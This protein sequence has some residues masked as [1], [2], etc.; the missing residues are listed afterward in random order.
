VRIPT[1]TK[2]VVAAALTAAIVSGSGVALAAPAPLRA[3][4]SGPL[5]GALSPTTDYSA[6]ASSGFDEVVIPTAWSV[7]EPAEGSFSLPAIS[8]LQ[9]AINSARAAGLSASLDIGV[10]YAPAWI[11]GVGG[12]TRFKDQYGDTFSGTT[13][14]GNDVA[15]AVTDTKV[16]SQL[17]A[18]IAFLG[19]HLHGLG[20][21]RLGGGPDNELRY[22]SGTSGSRANAYWFYDASS[23]ALLPAGTRGWVPG[24]GT[25]GQ[26]TSFLTAYDHAMAGYGTWLARQGEG[27]FP[28][29]T[30]I[31]L[32][33]PGWGERP[34]DVP[35]AETQLLRNTPDE[36]N[37][38]L[39]WLDLF[40]NLPRNGRIVAYTTYADAT[41]GVT[42]N[43]DPDRYIHS[44][45]PGGVLEGGESTGNGQTTAAGEAKMMADAKAWD[46]YVVNWFFNEQVQS[47]QQI[48]RQF[49]NTAS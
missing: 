29:A 27:D 44:L 39:D 30:K 8:R 16:R 9:D 47:P 20:S 26:A 46:W 25:I 14:S 2:L 40:A 33:L 21:V 48:G 49:A 45:L 35:V 13:G 17:G 22:P 19:Q 23:Q 31:E 43:P 12:G 34:T 38:G 42:G 4:A 28:A 10:Q 1:Y 18:Y 3:A 37:Q 32:L 7:I 6:L 24:T 11:F 5:L 36:V 41:Q 15:N